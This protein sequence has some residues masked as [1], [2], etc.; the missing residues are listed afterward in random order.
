MRTAAAIDIGG[1]HTKL[2]IVDET[3]AIIARGKVETPPQGDPAPL[4]DAIVEGL[5]P[6]LQTRDIAGVGVSVAGFLDATRGTMVGNANLP[7]L[8]GFPL[9][10]TLEDRLQQP[11]V[12]EVDSNASAIAEYRYGA[13]REAKR[14]L[15]IV[16]GTGV[17][18]GVIID[19]RLL[20]YTGECGGDLGHVIV[21]A[22]GRRCTCGATGCLEAMVCSA[23][24]AE[25][26]GGARVREVVGGARAGKQRALEVLSETGRW[27]GLGLAS[28]APLF[29]P[30]RIVIG[31]GVASA[32]ELLLQPARSSFANHA[33]EEFRTSVAIVGSTLEG[34]EGMLGAGSQCLSPMY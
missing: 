3:G 26:A 13:G 15:S 25:R 30:D 28:L 12:L 29:A 27:L 2:G 32:G 31:G 4:V 6:V 33:A 24:V 1:T 17:G 14:L 21:S 10:Q 20:R 7:A 8:C 5:Q 19:G 11:C 18:G 9:K 22:T 34:W 23:A 16:I